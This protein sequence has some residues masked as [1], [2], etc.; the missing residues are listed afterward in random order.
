[1][2]KEIEMIGGPHDGDFRS[3]P[4]EIP[5]GMILFA[6]PVLCKACSHGCI[7]ELMGKEEGLIVDMVSTPNLCARCAVKHIYI[8]ENNKLMYQNSISH[9][10]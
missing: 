4:D 1:M 10:G 3:W 9:G 7:L 6:A 5:E 8:L 2:V